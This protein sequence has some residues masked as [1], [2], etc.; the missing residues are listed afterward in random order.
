[1]QIG[2]KTAFSTDIPEY[3][4]WQQPGCTETI[5][6]WR[7]Q[8]TF[9]YWRRH[10]GFFD[11]TAPAPAATTATTTTGT[12]QAKLMFIVFHNSGFLRISCS[13]GIS[14]NKMER[15]TINPL[16][17]R[18]SLR[19]KHI[20]LFCHFSFQCKQPIAY[21][22]QLWKVTWDLLPRSK[23]LREGKQLLKIKDGRESQEALLL[24]GGR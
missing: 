18:I 13:K 3:V 6:K 22:Q 19:A 9:P 10:D 1:M 5:C 12:L 24:Q 15:E 14:S 2:N 23:G 4:C 20:N 7:W 17:C 11:I 8:P 16:C 21:E